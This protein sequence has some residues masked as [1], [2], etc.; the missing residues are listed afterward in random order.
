MKKESPCYG[1]T[2]QEWG[3]FDVL[4]GLTADLLPVVANPKAI[5]SPDSK[6]KDKGKVPSVYNRQG[7]VVGM[8]EWTRRVANEVD[9]A[10]WSAKRDY[11]ICIQTRAVRALDIDVPDGV[12]GTKIQTEIQ[13]VLG[14]ELPMRYRENSAKCLLAFRLEGDYAKRVIRVKE[15]WVDAA[16]GEVHPAWLIEFLAHGQQFVAAGT[17]SSGARIEWDWNGYE[18]FPVLQPA[19]FEKLWLALET[20]FAIA[21][22]ARGTMRQRG[23]SF[24]SPDA[25]AEALYEK[26]LALDVGGDGQLFIEC[27][28]K[29]NHSSDS[30]I[31]ETAYFPRGTNG[32]DLG[33]FKCMHAGCAERSDTDFEEALGLRDDMFDVEHVEPERDEKGEV[34]QGPPPYERDKMGRIE[35]RLYNILLALARP[36][37]IGREVKFDVYRDEDMVRFPGGDWRPLTDGDL[38]KLRVHLEK[39]VGFKPIGRELMRDAMSAHGEDFR[40]D[41]AIAWLE[42]LP[43][44]DGVPRIDGFMHRY[45]G[46]EDNAY[47]AAVGRYLWSALAGR[48][49]VPGVKADMAVIL[50]GEQGVIKSSAIAALA[51]T[52]D[53]FAEL[54]LGDQEDKLA[55]LM[56]G[57]SVVELGELRGFYS[58]EFEAIKAWLVRRF[59]EWVPKYREKSIKFYRRC[60]FIGTTNHV[61]FLV[62]ETGNRRF[63]PIEVQRA[64]IKALQRDRLQ[65]WAEARDLFMAEGVCWQDAETLA[66]G[67]HVKFTMHDTWEDDIAAWLQ[68]EDIDGSKPVQRPW[69]RVSDVLREA[70]NIDAR[71]ANAGLER[72]AG[73]VLKTLGYERQRVYIDGKQQRVFVKMQ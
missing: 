16:T 25:I 56:R 5:I 45:F 71:S 20:Q 35:P 50:R 43:E 53:Q 49:L 40:F 42:E 29:D 60:L 8:S 41:S 68:L 17:H 10:R 46:A 30:G 14:V 24:E 21:P 44:H 19:Q 59:D 7:H 26:G 65:L 3:T 12:L 73:K 70:L 38:V 15:K 39:K 64:D 54:N 55:R 51:P 67:E 34:V 37:V 69:L 4:L 23:E 36:D 72:R 6:M 52:E 22:S 31:T 9:I 61:E 27:P 58:K 33:H 63:L 66:K 28:W 18:D 13:R 32:Y 2:I 11:G 47:A 57:K 48:T 62:D 1:A